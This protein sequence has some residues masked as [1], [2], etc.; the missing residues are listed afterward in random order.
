[1]TG[2]QASLLAMS[3]ASARKS[4]SSFDKLKLKLTPSRSDVNLIFQSSEMTEA[5]SR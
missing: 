1:M 3:V 2:A 5:F 4:L